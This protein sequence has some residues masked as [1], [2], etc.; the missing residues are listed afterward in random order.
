MLWDLM[1]VKESMEEVEN[2]YVWFFE[3]YFIYFNV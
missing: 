1:V 3:K 2:E